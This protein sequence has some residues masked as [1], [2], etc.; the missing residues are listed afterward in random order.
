MSLIQ[1]AKLN[2]HNPYRYLKDV[3]SACLLNPPADSGNCCRI[4]GSGPRLITAIHWL[5]S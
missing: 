4:V 1:S 5:A 3:P 2:G